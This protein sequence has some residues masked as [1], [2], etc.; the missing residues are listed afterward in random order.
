[1]NKNWLKFQSFV[2][3]HRT[4]IQTIFSEVP[5]FGSICA[6]ARVFVCYCVVKC[7]GVDIISDIYAPLP[8]GSS[9][10]CVVVLFIG[11]CL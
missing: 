8:A 9:P 4:F 2:W 7:V 6:A 3:G 1:M 5:L 11:L 10:A